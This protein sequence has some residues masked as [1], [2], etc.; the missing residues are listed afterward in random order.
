MSISNNNKLLDKCILM[1]LKL[2]A[3]AQ[4]CD[5]TRLLSGHMFAQYVLCGHMIAQYALSGQFCWFPHPHM[6]IVDVLADTRG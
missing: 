2:C 6:D 4:T 1:E 5:Y 3:T